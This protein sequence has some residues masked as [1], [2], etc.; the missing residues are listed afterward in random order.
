MESLGNKKK[1][2][3]RRTTL[4]GF[5]PDDRDRLTIIVVARFLLFSLI[6][7]RC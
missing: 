1:N 5:E 3:T 6:I 4:G 2:G 7:K